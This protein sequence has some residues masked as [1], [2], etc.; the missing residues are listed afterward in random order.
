MTNASRRAAFQ[1]V[2]GLVVSATAACGSSDGGAATDD[3][4]IDTARDVV[5]LPVDTGTCPP[6]PVVEGAACGPEVAGGV[7]CTTAAK[8]TACGH[9]A[10]Y[11]ATKDCTCRT[12]VWACETKI[13][14]C[15]A[16]APGT[17]DDATCTTKNPD[18][19][20][21]TDADAASDADAA[22]TDGATDAAD[23]G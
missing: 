14:D 21:G 5:T 16:S 8:C 20:A 3:S 4:G 7:V 19:D 9:D 6:T 22:A 17:Y 18:R 23:G 1:L 10:Y 11:L 12:G 15:G 13:L 2:F